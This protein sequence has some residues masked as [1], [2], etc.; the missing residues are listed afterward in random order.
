MNKMIT[1]SSTS[2]VLL[3]IALLFGCAG[4]DADTDSELEDEL[5]LGTAELAIQHPDREQPWEVRLDC[6]VSC[7]ED[8]LSLGAK[9][10]PAV[11]ACASDCAFLSTI[12]RAG[13]DGRAI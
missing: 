6:R 2:P 5:S 4:T 13:L 11:Q 3:A 10:S 7:L 8:C 1:V 12:A 9:N